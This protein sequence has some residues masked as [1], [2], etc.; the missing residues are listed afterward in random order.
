MAKLSQQKIDRALSVAGTIAAS[1]ADN[2]TVPSDKALRQCCLTGLKIVTM[3]DQISAAI[4]EEP[5]I[6]EVTLDNWEAYLKL[7]DVMNAI[8]K[9]DKAVAAPESAEAPKT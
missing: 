9:R 5:S 1:I 7:T 3:M 2:G 4:D 8:A 6:L